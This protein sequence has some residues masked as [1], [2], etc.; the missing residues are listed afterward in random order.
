MTSITRYVEPTVL[1]VTKELAKMQ[2]RVTHTAE[3][4]LFTDVLIPAA[5]QEAEQL[6]QRT[7]CRT[8]WRLALDG[9]PCGPHIRLPYP[10]VQALAGFQ[11][12]NL[13][14]VWTTLDAAL[15][16]TD[17]DDRRVYLKAGQYWPTDIDL[18]YEGSVRLDYV[19]GFANPTTGT[20]EEQDTAIQAAVPGAI[21]AWL[22]TR[23]ATLYEFREQIIAGMDIKEVPCMTGL[24][25]PYRVFGGIQ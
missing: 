20:A 2:C 14:G 25:D 8:T 11:Y 19:A 12:R 6:M 17:L 24:L 4:S 16:G 21:R 13:S 15:Y 10:T 23:I 7:I 1:P 5:R 9:W 22:L 3:D 18:N